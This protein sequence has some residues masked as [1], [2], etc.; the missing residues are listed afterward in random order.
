MAFP[1]FVTAFVAVLGE[2]YTR[3]RQPRSIGFDASASVDSD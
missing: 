2:T 3:E 1:L